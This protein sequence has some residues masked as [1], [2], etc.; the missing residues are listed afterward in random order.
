MMMIIVVM[1]MTTMNVNDDTKT[2]AIRPMTTTFLP[3]SS[4]AIEIFYALC[5][6]K[7]VARYLTHILCFFSFNCIIFDHE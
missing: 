6:L 1:M 4:E 5:D 7:K 2:I 3:T